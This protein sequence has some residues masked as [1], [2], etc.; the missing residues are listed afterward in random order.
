VA[1]RPGRSAGRGKRFLSYDVR[2]QFVAATAPVV[3]PGPTDPARSR[4]VAPPSRC[5][6]RAIDSLRLRSDR[7]FA[8]LAEIDPIGTGPDPRRPMIQG[9]RSHRSCAACRV[10]MPVRRRPEGCRG[11][12]PAGAVDGSPGGPRDRR[13]PI[14]DRPTAVHRSGA[15]P[16]GTRD[17][18]THRSG[19][20]GSRG[21]S[22]GSPAETTAGGRR[23]GGRRCP[24]IT[25]RGG[26]PGGARNRRRPRW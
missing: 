22:F 3:A 10:S 1:G 23:P 4:Q 12:R 19:H 15:S 8:R 13:N 17:R 14:V 6:L 16:D 7:P 18:G 9:R 25:R 24:G 2:R 11:V 26:A 20:H 21:R 5:C